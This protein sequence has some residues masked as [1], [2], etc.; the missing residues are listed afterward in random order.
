MEKIFVRFWKKY[1]LIDILGMI[2]SGNP[3][4]RLKETTPLSPEINP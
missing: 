2:I 4:R 1:L 3:K